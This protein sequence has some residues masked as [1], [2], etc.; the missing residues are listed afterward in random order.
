MTTAQHRIN[1]FQKRQRYDYQ[2][3]VASLI[4]KNGYFH[5]EV[6]LDIETDEKLKL[7]WVEM[8]KMKVKA[9]GGKKL[10]EPSKENS[11]GKLYETTLVR[12]CVLLTGKYNGEDPEA[13]IKEA[14]KLVGVW[15]CGVQI[16]KPQEIKI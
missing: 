6:T 1:E 9:G 13:L 11:D 10:P 12:Q 3:M 15:Q 2:G 7:T 5:Y 4:T 16:K 8:W 14:E